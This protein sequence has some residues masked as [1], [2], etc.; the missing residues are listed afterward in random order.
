MKNRTVIRHS[1]SMFALILGATTVP[2]QTAQ[3]QTAQAQTAP[4]AIAAAEADD[5]NAIIV[6]ARRINERLQDVPAAISV[7]TADDLRRKGIDDLMDVAQNTVGFAYEAISPL[8]V[9]T[10]IRGQLNLRTTSPVQNVPVNIDGIYLQRGYMVDQGLVELQQIEIIKGPQ[11]A[12]Y[13]RNAFAGVVN[14][15]TRAPSLEKIEAEIQGTVGNHDRYDARGLI[16]IP[17]IKDKLAVMAAVGHSQFDGTWENQ[18]P[19]ANSTDP[20]A[21]TRGNLGGWNKETYQ[22]RV[23][24]KP[25]ESLTIDA[26]YIRTER[27]FDQ[28]ASYSMGT[29]AAATTAVNTLNASP[30]TNPSP[31]AFAPATQ[32]RLFVGEVPVLPVLAPGEVRPNGLLIDPRAYGLEGPTDVASAKIEWNDGGPFSALYQFGYTAAA[33]TQRGNAMRNPTQS[34]TLTSFVPFQTFVGTLFDSSGSDSSFKGYSHEVRFSYDNEGPFRGLFGFNYSRTKDI[35][36]NANEI[37]PVNSTTLLPATNVYFP[38][39]PGLPRNAAG[40]PG[41][42]TYLQ[43]DEDI[44]SAFAFVAYTPSDKLEITLEGRYTIEDQK[45][46]DFLGANPAAPLVQL[47]DPPRLNGTTSFFT[48]RGSITYRATPDSLFYASVARGVKSG[49]FNGGTSIPQVVQ[50]TYAPET[51]WTYEIGSKNQFFDRRL[52]VNL[53]AY[54]T[55]WRSLQTNVVRLRANGTPDTAFL[56]PTIVGNLG[57]VNVWGGEVELAWRVSNMLTLDGGASYNSAKYIDA[58]TSQRFGISGNCNGIVCAAV[59]TPPAL[60]IG[61]NNVERRP[62]FEAFG[63]ATLN[64][65]FSDK[66]SWFI[67]GDFTYQTKQFIDEANLAFTPGRFIMNAGAGVTFGIFSVNAWVRNLADKQYASS[68][69]FLIGT[70]G[71][72][73]ASYVPSLGDRRTF[74]LTGAVR[75]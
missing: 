4:A 63:G 61:G 3:A 50:R 66:N 75:F 72:L 22:V 54:H 8:V 20:G 19:L 51:N 2:T 11:S 49:G 13:G 68:S 1:A 74:G 28:F 30:V 67:R 37:H 59:G 27:F 53:A 14:L 44:F 6:T 32:N 41:R 43:R 48:P 12:L 33:V 38:I 69:L 10:S 71:A 52:T 34:A 70:G 40:A 25:V 31:F 16:S 58:T 39:G 24:A 57:G 56:V 5:A 7:V 15:T 18:H 60:P 46:I 23:I 26:M 35:E 36:S 45:I 55:S 47:V 17:I 62:N 64:G 21:R 73:S 29:T 65:D 42:L 9:Q